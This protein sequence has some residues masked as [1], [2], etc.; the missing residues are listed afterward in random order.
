[1]AKKAKD[2]R[3]QRYPCKDIK[4]IVVKTDFGKKEVVKV[5]CRRCDHCL[6]NRGDDKIG[7]LLAEGLSAGLVLAVTHTYN[8]E[9]H[10]SRMGAVQRNAEHITEFM[11]KI[12]NKARSELRR[13]LCNDLRLSVR[14]LDKARKLLTDWRDYRIVPSE[15]DQVW[16]SSLQLNA[17]QKRKVMDSDFSISLSHFSAYEFGE[18]THRGHWHSLLFFKCREPVPDELLL[19]RDFAECREWSLANGLWLPR[20]NRRLMSKDRWKA[21]NNDR[22]VINLARHEGGTTK[23]VMQEWFAWKYGRVSVQDCFAE[24]A[25]ENPLN[26]AAGMANM[27]AYVANYYLKKPGIEKMVALEPGEADK[28]S[29]SHSLGKDFHLARA[30]R[31][32]TTGKP[33]KDMYYSF[34]GVNRH[35][36]AG[37]NASG[38]P[39]KKK[40]AAQL[41]EPVPRPY[42]ISSETMRDHYLAEFH[43]VWVE[44]HGPDRPIPSGTEGECERGLPLDPVQRDLA[45]QALRKADLT[46]MQNRLCRRYWLL[47]ATQPAVAF[48]IEADASESL[49]VA[50]TMYGER[51]VGIWKAQSKAGYW[52]LLGGR[53]DDQTFSR[54]D[55]DLDEPADADGWGR[56]DLSGMHRGPLDRRTG[57]RQLS[58]GQK[59]RLRALTKKTKKK[60]KTR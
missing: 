31:D 52:P 4:V 14:E 26:P 9:T 48:K 25:E 53:P 30:R 45:K 2:S 55:V 18:N 24:A 8:N 36:M 41:A 40:M 43:R 22:E 15:A 54:V 56:T 32:A 10:E 17:A 34:P 21:C 60:A 11:Q 37:L 35:Y 59:A 51:Q 6:Q 42:Q 1:M 46:P 20:I 19:R 50:R 29:Q 7:S 5:S 33:V 13:D 27:I 3:Q 23:D 28:A 38:D 58:E 57:D 49:D 44:C 16:F 47:K 12:R 39:G